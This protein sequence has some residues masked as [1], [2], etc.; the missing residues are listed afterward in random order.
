MNRT[1]YANNNNIDCIHVWDWDDYNVI[2]KAFR[3]T[4]DNDVHVV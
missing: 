2:A 3:D 1:I 4:A